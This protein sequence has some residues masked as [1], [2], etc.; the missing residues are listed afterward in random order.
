MKFFKSHIKLFLCFVICTFCMLMF[1][2]VK[3]DNAIISSGTYN[4]RRFYTGYCSFFNN[5]SEFEYFKSS[6]ILFPGEDTMK[7]EDKNIVFECA[8]VGRGASINEKA[9]YAILYNDGTLKYVKGN[10]IEMPGKEIGYAF[11]LLSQGD[12]FH[13]ITSF[14]VSLL[15]L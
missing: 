15:T 13:R 12:L 3:D 4:T 10:L 8:V 9:Y 7:F 14:F 1:L 11:E 2:Y 6:N 5:V